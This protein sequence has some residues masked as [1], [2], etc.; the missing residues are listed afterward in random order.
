MPDMRSSAPGAGSAPPE[1]DSPSRKLGLQRA[2]QKQLP[3]HQGFGD[4]KRAVGA[5]SL[6]FNGPLIVNNQNDQCSL[7]TSHRC[8]DAAEL[9]E[10]QDDFHAVQEQVFGDV[11]SLRHN[12]DTAS[13]LG[14]IR[15]ARIIAAAHVR[16]LSRNSLWTTP[17]Q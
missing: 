9:K 5:F 6:L 17:L 11:Q 8:L 3:K 1:P 16:Q 4:L 12:G 15:F 13:A 10:L 14:C 2:L 7:D